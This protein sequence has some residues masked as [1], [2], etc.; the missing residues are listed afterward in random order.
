VSP[1]LKDLHWCFTQ[2]P[3]HFDSDLQQMKLRAKAWAVGD[4]RG[5]GTSRR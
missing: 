3:D 1:V 2:A 4:I 5:R